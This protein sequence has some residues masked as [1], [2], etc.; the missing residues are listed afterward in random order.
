M[1]MTLRAPPRNETGREPLAIG[2]VEKIVYYA[3]HRLAQIPQFASLPPD[4][5]HGIRLAAMVFPFKVNSY[6]LDNLID[7][8]AGDEDPMFRLVFPHPDML[9]A[10]DREK[11]DRLSRAGDEAAIASEV[12][13]IRDAMNPHGSDQLANIPMFEGSTV[14]GIQ[15]KYD[16]TA[17]FFAKQGQTCHS[18]CTF[19]FRWPQFVQTGVDKFEADDGEQLY[20]YLRA[21][22]EVTDILM[23]GGDP[24]VMSTRRLTAYLEPL[25]SPEFTH[26][27]NIRIGTKAI[28]YW[29]YRFLA[30]KDADDL[31]E[32]IARLSDA[33]KHVAIMAH[34]NHWRE[35]QPEPVHQA[36]VALRRAGAVIRTQSP[37][38]RHINDD[39]T[40]WSRM[41]A[42]QV[43]IGMVPYYMFM[44]RD[45]GANHY[46]GTGLARA[47]SIYQEATTSVSGICRTARGPV[48]SAGPGKI[49]V[50][51]KIEVE[52]RDHFLL[53]FLQARCKDWLHK[54]FLAEYSESASWLNDLTPPSDQNAFFFEEEYGQFLSAKS[55]PPMHEPMIEMLA[56]D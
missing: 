55:F 32:L 9:L 25:L 37:I 6:V 24:M 50:L 49:H 44:E 8:N 33:G 10:N 13:R 26:V 7:W 31:M 42:D 1:P 14:E 19:C 21:H 47:L 52:G 23:T 34:V 4:L 41:W 3:N 5:A 2:R 51:G 11:L 46:F 45:T 28:S 18:Y 43:S 27:R 16:E 35:L 30:G 15:H 53:S 36:T 22:P 54:P 48:M 40:V 38:L 12:A 29:P 20:T 56:H 17:L 39:A